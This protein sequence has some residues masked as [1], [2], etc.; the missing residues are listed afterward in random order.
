[1]QL[2]KSLNL[3]GKIALCERKVCQVCDEDGGSAC[4]YV[5]LGVIFGCS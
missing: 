5:I 2:R 1:M 4:R 3:D